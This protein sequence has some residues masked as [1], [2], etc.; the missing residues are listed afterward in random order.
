MKASDFKTTRAVVIERPY[1]ANLR[2]IKLTEPKE[3]AFV[4][5]T[6]FSSISTG[7]DMKTYKGMQHPEQCYFPLVPGYETAG[8]VVAVPENPEAI[9]RIPESARQLKVGDRV[10]VNVE[11]FCGECFFCKK[12]FV[13]NCTD[14]NG[15]W[16]LGCRIDVCAAWGGG[17]EYTIKD[18][19][20]TNDQFDYMVKVP[21]NVTDIQA[22]L[23][24]LACVPLKGIKRMTLRPNETIVVVGAGMVGISAIQELKIL[25]PTLK[26]VCIERNAFRRSIAEKYADLVVAPEDAVE[27]I[28]DFTDGKMADQLMECSG[29]PEV[30]G[31]LHKYIKDG[32]W[33]DDDIP[34]HIH[35][36]GDYPDKLIFDHYHRWFVKNATITMTCALRGGCKEQVLQWISEGKFDTEGLPI[37]IWP[38]S[39]CKEAFEYLNEKGADVFKIVFDW[40]K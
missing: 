3:D 9:S 33:E 4:A 26:V 6:L 10:T 7:T 1:E 38:V 13:T 32:G 35:L 34:A 24:F 40:S 15:G 36:Q 11:T 20:T 2:E 17:S 12:G 30:V 14:K 21:D 23:A 8:V 28:R 18:S 16:A 27:V 19:Y 22:V 25:E 31:T 37:E 5:K 39:K 29:N